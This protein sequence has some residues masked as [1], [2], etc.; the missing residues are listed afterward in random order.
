VSRIIHQRHVHAAVSVRVVPAKINLVVQGLAGLRQGSAGI[1]DVI[2]AIL[3][4]EIGAEHLKDGVVQAVRILEVE[5]MDR[6][7]AAI[8]GIAFFVEQGIEGQPG[9]YS[10]VNRVSLEFDQ[11]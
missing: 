7:G 8:L 2:R 3:G 4:E 1:I 10:I 9:D 11:K 6:S 5:I